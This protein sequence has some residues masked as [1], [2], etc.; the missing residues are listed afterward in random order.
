MAFEP[1]A[2][3]VTLRHWHVITDSP[4]VSFSIFQPLYMGATLQKGTI[5]F[6]DHDKRQF[7]NTL[8]SRVDQH[9]REQQHSSHANPAMVLKT[10]VLLLA[11]VGPFV[12]LLVFQPTFGISLLLWLLMGLA[13]AGIGMSVMH[14]AN[15]GAYAANG[16]VNTWVSYSINILG[17]SGH[18]WK[19]QHN[20]LHHTYTNIT[21]MDDDIDDKPALRFSPHT[22]VK[23]IH[24]FQWLHAFVMYGLTTLYWVFAK[25]FV[26][27]ARYQ[28]N[29]VIRKSATENRKALLKIYALK[30]TYLAIFIGLPILVGLPFWSIAVGFVTMHFIAGLVLTVIFQ[31][32]H[33]VEGTSHPLPCAAGNIENEWAIHQMNTTVNF[34][35]HNKWLSWYVGGLNF[36]VEHHL[37]PRICHV[38]YPRIAP[39]VRQTAA[40]FGVPYLENRTFWQALRSHIVTLRRF[41]QMPDL[42]NEAIG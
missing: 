5:K 26:Q 2:F 25:D 33:T 42:M 14:D 20:L 18:N 38:H 40:E 39:I 23:G 31:L 29:G 37:F 15:H 28:R 27:F 35:P 1:T 7:F 22:Q 10:V 9:F 32:A 12:A 21:H 34:A 16:K 3:V 19:L 17:A 6:I 30:I 24:R 13:M 8:K 4:L 41:G 36:Q 11:Y